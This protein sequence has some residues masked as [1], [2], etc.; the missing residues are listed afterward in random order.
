M[1]R[2]LWMM[3]RSFR[4]SEKVC[5]VTNGPSASKSARRQ[6][7]DRDLVLEHSSFFL[8]AFAPSLTVWKVARGPLPFNSCIK[9][10][11][12]VTINSKTIA[13]EMP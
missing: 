2:F 6:L 4:S 1:V 13:F 12:E 11:H 7:R 5:R 9:G 8:D 10:T 3:F